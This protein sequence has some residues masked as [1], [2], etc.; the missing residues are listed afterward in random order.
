MYAEID[1]L[2]NDSNPCYQYICVFNLLPSQARSLRIYC[3]NIF[4]A[5]STVQLLMTVGISLS[6]KKYCLR[7]AYRSRIG[8]GPSVQHVDLKKV[9]TG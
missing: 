2:Q 6:I 3:F 8:T 4:A 7:V 9:N 1:S 5:S